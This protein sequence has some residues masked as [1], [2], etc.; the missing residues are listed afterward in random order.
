MKLVLKQVLKILL[1]IKKISKISEQKLNNS[2]TMRQC[3]N[4]L[5]VKYQDVK[6]LLMVFKHKLVKCKNYG[7]ILKNVKIDFMTI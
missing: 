1:T 2:N 3:S 6:K 4:S 5:K 7:N